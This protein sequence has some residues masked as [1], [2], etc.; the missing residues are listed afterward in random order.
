MT[1][2]IGSAGY[3]INKDVFYFLTIYGIKY[4]SITDYTHK[5]PL[6]DKNKLTKIEYIEL[7]SH[8]SKL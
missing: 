6:F 5:H 8:L 3:K 2:N 1:N 7:S 4:N